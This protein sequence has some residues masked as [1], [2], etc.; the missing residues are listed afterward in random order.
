MD[1][2][3]RYVSPE[4]GYRSNPKQHEDRYLVTYVW[5]RPNAEYRNGR[6]TILV[7]KKILRDGWLPYVKEARE[8]DPM[9]V[10]NITMGVVPQFGMDFP[11]RLIP[12]APLGQWRGPQIRWNE[13]L[14]DQKRN[15]RAVIRNKLII[16]KDSMPREAL[17]N[18][19]AEVVEVEKGTQVV[20]TFIQGQ[21]LAGIEQEKASVLASLEEMTGQTPVMRGQNPTQARAAQQLDVLREESLQLVFADI[22]QA[23][24]AHELTARFLLAIARNRYTPERIVQIVGK[25][26]AGAAL[27]FGR[28]NLNA[29]VRVKTGSMRPRNHAL[30][31]WKLNELLAAGAFVDPRTGKNNTDLFWDMSEWGTMNRSFDARKTQR[32]R[33]QFEGVA[34]LLRR[35]VVKPFDHEDHQLHVEEHLQTMS[36]PE[37][38]DADMEVQA[39][40][41]THIE[42]HRLRAVMGLAPEALIGA[43]VT[44]EYDVTGGLGGNGTPRAMNTTPAAG[45]KVSGGAAQPALLQAS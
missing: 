36:R 27:T 14:T 41:I 38:Y 22:D 20:P 6:Y 1:R 10:H 15:R 19:H 45:L 9:D 40:M 4:F 44:G 31:E 13:L 28:A 12:P 26:R 30:R 32:N 5:Q 25:D 35:Q 39:L 3:N 42:E 34:M 7:G 24:R 43:P 8:I 37:W 2:L 11:G 29:D 18:S 33:A 16:E 21:P 23:E 17:T